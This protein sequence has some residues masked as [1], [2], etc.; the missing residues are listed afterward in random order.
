M[1]ELRRRMRAELSSPRFDPCLPRVAEMPP[2]GPDW[3]HEIKH[4]GFGILAHG[5]GGAVRLMSRAGN[6]LAGRFPQI[7]EAML[8]L[9]VQSCVIDGEA[10]VTDDKGLAA[11]DLL[12]GRHHH[13]GAELCAFDTIELNGED[14]RRQTIQDRKRALSRLLGR[15]KHGILVNEYFEGD[16][17]IIYKHACALGCEGIVSKRLGTSY[18]AGRSRNWLKIKNP[19]APAVRRLEEVDWT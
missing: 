11:F 4:D 17:A 15:F 16:G 13:P 6:D 10:I 9:S 14:L 1:R 18:R 12:R 8:S 2:A 7:V 5:R 19:E 3:I